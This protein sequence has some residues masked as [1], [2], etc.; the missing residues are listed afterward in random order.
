MPP[1]TFRAHPNRNPT[2]LTGLLP[3]RLGRLA[4]TEGAVAGHVVTDDVSLTGE[5][6]TA[7]GRCYVV[8]RHLSVS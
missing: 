8:T 1:S 6:G 4:V 2:G 7:S 5:I 3:P